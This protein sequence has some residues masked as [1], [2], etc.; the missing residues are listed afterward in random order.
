MHFSCLPFRWFLF[1][2]VIEA[3]TA[4]QIYHRHIEQL[5][6]Y[7]KEHCF[8]EDADDFDGMISF[9]HGLG[10]F[11]R[12]RSTVVLK[13]QWLIDL[14]KQLITIPNFIEMVRKLNCFTFT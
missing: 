13:A 6:N 7:A 9:Y 3:L 14:L 12:H 4:Q 11:I 8:I 10:M 1:E 5:Q 2:K